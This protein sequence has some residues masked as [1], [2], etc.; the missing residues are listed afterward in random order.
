M[1]RPERS[2]EVR[3]EAEARRDLAFEILRSLFCEFAE[4][5]KSGTID[6]MMSSYSA[7]LASWRREH[8]ARRKPAEPNI[9]GQP[10]VFKPDT[11]KK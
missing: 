10:E 7:A 8:E 4:L 3:N 9:S 2:E 11:F 5:G 6:T 1:E